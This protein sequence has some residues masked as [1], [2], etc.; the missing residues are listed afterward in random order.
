M[1]PTARARSL[2]L[3]LGTLG[4]PGAVPGATPREALPGAPPWPAALAAR[5]ASE[6]DAPGVHEAARTRHRLLAPLRRA[7]LPGATLALVPAGPARTRL[8]P[9]V[10][11]IAR[12]VARGD[13]TTAYVCEARVCEL[14]T[15]DPAVLARQLARVPGRAL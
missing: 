3:A 13:R 1:S 9:L 8:A 7:F 11:A 4:L 2:A 12:K 10:P 5:L 14:P 6:R 15:A